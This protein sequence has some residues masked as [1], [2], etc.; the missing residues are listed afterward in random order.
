MM[1]IIRSKHSTRQI[2]R[3]FKNN[4]ARRR[5]DVK[6]DQQHPADVVAPTIPKAQFQHALLHPQKMLPNGWNPPPLQEDLM[7]VPEYP[8]QVARTKNKP[9]NA[10]GFL[11]VYSEFR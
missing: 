9:N 8:F 6:K 3:L 7:N 4:P 2:K 1:T 11:P 10:M 5:I